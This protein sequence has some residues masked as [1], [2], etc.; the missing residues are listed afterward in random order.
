MKKETGTLTTKGQLVIPAGLRRKYRM[1]KGTKVTF[2]PKENSFEVQPLTAEF[3]R[4]L[5]GSWKTDGAA[6]KHLLEGRKKD[7][8][9]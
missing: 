4:S 6:L 8:E 2:V 9:L 1:R 5:R 7:R 3:I